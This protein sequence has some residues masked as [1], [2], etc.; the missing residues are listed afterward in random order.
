M[1]FLADDTEAAA[2]PL[3]RTM[4]D[5]ILPSQLSAVNRSARRAGVDAEAECQAELK[6]RTGDLS[7]RAVSTFIEHLE[8]LVSVPAR[9][10]K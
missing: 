2:D 8:Q 9:E 1:A 3:A 10:V 6:C 7:R 5:M 4:G